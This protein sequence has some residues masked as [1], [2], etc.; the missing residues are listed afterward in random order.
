MQGNAAA[1][2]AQM[3]QQIHQLAAAAAA[4]ASAY[5]AALAAQLAAA[6]SGAFPQDFAASALAGSGGLLPYSTSQG[7]ALP[8]QGSACRA[9]LLIAW[10]NC[11]HCLTSNSMQQKDLGLNIDRC[12]IPTSCGLCPRKQ[13]D[14]Q[15]GGERFQWA[16]GHGCK[17]RC[18]ARLQPILRAWQVGQLCSQH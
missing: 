15:H 11:F 2:A 13:H 16:S 18:R 14:L 5:P 10:Y 3:K 6:S 4:A 17:R 9:Q 8:E 7:M 1:T 12:L